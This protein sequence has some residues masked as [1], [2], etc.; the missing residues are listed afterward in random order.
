MSKKTVKVSEV[1]EPT[2][3]EI[4]AAEAEEVAE[5]LERQEE[6]R[7]RLDEARK[8]AVKAF[9]V[10]P[11]KPE[12]V[13]GMIDFLFGDDAVDPE[14]AISTV[15]QAID[16]AKSFGATDTETVI[17]V[18]GILLEDEDGASHIVESAAYAERLYGTAE[19]AAQTVET[20]YE[21]YGEDLLG[22][23]E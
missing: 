3:E 7:H 15:E 4:A 19:M 22:E 11:P 18:A 20:Y 1:K 13:K 23:E 5:A 21:V 10:D 9:G 6:N 17:A 14:F 8:V 12:M 16:V 2:E